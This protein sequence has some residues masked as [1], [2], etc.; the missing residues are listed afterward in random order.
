[1]AKRRAT[2]AEQRHLDRVALLP[3]ALCYLMGEPQP[4]PTR[5]H[6]IR[7]G[8]GASQRASHFLTVPLC[9]EHH[10]GPQG[11]HGDRTLWRIANIDELS[12]LAWTIEMLGRSAA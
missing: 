11:I 8:Q 9:D 7:E 12:A 2:V 6:H 3:C 4:T 5:V 1:M 10:Q